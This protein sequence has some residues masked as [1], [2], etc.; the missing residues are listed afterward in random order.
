MTTQQFTRALARINCSAE[1]NS[2]RDGAY[3]VMVD[4]PDG[5]QFANGLHTLVHHDMS[6][7]AATDRARV[8]REALADAQAALPLVKCP[9]DCQCMEEPE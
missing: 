1:I 9:A 3:D 8:R 2:F 5:Y 7:Y 6:A 4:A